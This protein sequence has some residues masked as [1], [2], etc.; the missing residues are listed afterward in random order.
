MKKNNL[1]F[2]LLVCLSVIFTPACSKDDDS[3]T[4]L[5]AEEKQ[6]LMDVALEFYFLG[7]KVFME[8]NAAS[9]GEEPGISAP[10]KTGT[11]GLFSRNLISEVRENLDITGCVVLTTEHSEE[12]NKMTITLDF[13][14]GCEGNDGSTRSGKIIVT[15]I[16]DID[17]E[18]ANAEI[19]YLNYRVDEFTVNGKYH[20]ITDYATL[21]QTSAGEYTISKAEGA[22]TTMKFDLKYVEQQ[23]SNLHVT[24]KMDA[25]TTKGTKTWNWRAEYTSP[26]VFSL[27][28]NY[29]IS[30]VLTI[31]HASDN[32]GTLNY[33]AG[34]C[35]EFA[36]ITV[37]GEARIISLD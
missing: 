10:V 23:N 31:Y 8:G 28:C 14:S 24:G 11:N 6:E 20:T 27:S 37:N 3:S 13:G 35:D 22:S 32:V 1:L 21:T 19:E 33:G 17:N 25:Q 15:A 16:F 7:N 12:E 36:T 9:A 30:G 34:T 29:P 18:M 2:T 5:N 4:P 26:V